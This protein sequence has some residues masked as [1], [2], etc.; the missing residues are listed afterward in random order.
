MKGN[1]RMKKTISLILF[2]AMLMQLA[3][4]G[5]AEEVINLH[6]AVDGKNTGDGSI[7]N[8]FGSI[9]EV[10]G[11]IRKNSTAYG[12]KQINVLMHGGEYKL[13]SSVVFS[14]NDSGSKDK[15]LIITAYG[16]EK[17]IIKGA[18]ELNARDFKNITDPDILRKLPSEARCRVLMYNLSNAGLKY[19]LTNDNIPYLYVNDIMKTTARYPN[20]S[21]LRAEKANGEKSFIFDDFDITRWEA[22]KDLRFIGSSGATYFWYNMPAAVKNSKITVNKTVRKNTDFYVENLIEELDVPGEYFVDRETNILYYYP[23]VDISNAR[24]EIASFFDTAIKMTNTENV[25]FD[26]LTFDKTGGSVFDISGAENVIIKNCGF[27]YSQGRGVIKLKGNNS[28][29]TDNSFYGCAK[30]V[31]TFHGGALKSLTRGNIKIKNNRISM[32]GFD[33]KMSIISSG[34]SSTSTPSDF[35]NSI[36]NNIIQDC[37][38]FM[39]ISCGANDYKIKYNE[40]VNQGYLIGDGGAIYMGRSNTKYGMEVAYNYIHDGHLVDPNYAYCGLYSDDGYGGSY[41]HHNV[42][43]NMYQGMIV[44]YGMNC[45]FNNNLFV[46]NSRKFGGQSMMTH[47]GSNGPEESGHQDMMYNEVKSLLQRTTYGKVVAEHYPEMEAS[48]S[49]KPYF[50]VWNTE[51]VGNVSVNSGGAISRPWHPYYKADGVTPIISDE[52]VLV[53]KNPDAL[54]YAERYYG[55]N[56][57][58]GMIVDDFELYA[59]KITDSQGNDLNLTE[60]GNPRM[61]Y[62]AELFRDPDNQDYTLT[63]KF[64]SDVS[65]VNEIDMSV[66]SITETSNPEIYSVPSSTVVLSVPFDDEENVNG[67]KVNFTWERV[68]NASKYRLVIAKDSELTDVVSDETFNDTGDALIKTKTLEAN[69][70]YYWQVSA[71]GL[72]KNDTF[73]AVSD[74]HSFTTGEENRIEKSGLEY[75]VSLVN[76][77]LEKYNKGLLEFTETNIVK[78][79]SDIVQ[80]AEEILKNET[81][82]EEINNIENEVYYLLS[83]SEENQNEYAPKINQVRLDEN[84]DNVYVACSGLKKNAMLSVLVTNPNYDIASADSEFDLSAVQYADTLYADESGTIEFVFN[85]RVENEDRSGIYTI[86]V[87]NEAGNILNKKYSYGKIYADK[88]VYKNAKGEEFGDL[89]SCGDGKVTISCDI[90]NDTD[91]EISPSVVTAYYNS[92]RLINVSIDSVGSIGGHDLKIAE[93]TVNL[94][95]NKTESIKVMFMDSMITLKPLTECRVIYEK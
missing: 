48:L 85:T 50:A 46:N 14:E 36:E 10:L 22:A 73:E 15:P 89:K 1:K 23:D 43:A 54:S 60:L 13:D 40:I 56:L 76:S 37:M 31:I 6:V 82:Q 92:G 7:A 27:N 84:T 19:S 39:G 11:H 18:A 24:I 49:R 80:K 69:Q 41:F 68:R 12:E 95:L 77:K 74:V 47:V 78:Q 38:T 83:Y 81:N 71:Y 64:K 67:Q 90:Y 75:A 62:D 35:G 58:K 53:E 26:G 32:C 57:Y 45:K 4:T 66:M 55:T 42:V 21:H 70:K 33:E 91:K 34:A 8:P 44:N 20:D 28:Q 25:I 17:P 16:E 3:V 5:Y 63:D 65:T 93:W 9:E 79:L 59:A 87:R 51:V 2:G 29:I 61:E 30:N 72:A 52:A 88:L 86:Y 94:D